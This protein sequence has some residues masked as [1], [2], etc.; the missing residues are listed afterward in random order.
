[1]SDLR[2]YARQTQLR[3]LIGLGVLVLGVGEGLIYLLY[4]RGA[5]LLGLICLAGAALPIIA[6]VVVLKIMEGLASS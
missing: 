1:M 4:G 3:M 6:V 5:A 2:K